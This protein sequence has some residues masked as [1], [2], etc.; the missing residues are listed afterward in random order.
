MSQVVAKPVGTISR[1]GNAV[2]I[3]SMNDFPP[4]VGGVITLQANTNYFIVGVGLTTANRFAWVGNVAMTGLWTIGPA[5]LTYTGT[6]NMFSTT[7]G[8]LDAFRC[9]FNCPNGNFFF[10]Q[11]VSPFPF[12]GLKMSGVLVENCQNL[13]EIDG[14]A[15]AIDDG[16]CFSCVNGFILRTV[17]NFT[18]SLRQFNLVDVSGT[19][20]DF[21]NSTWDVV[22]HRDVIIGTTTAATG[23]SGLPNSGNINVGQ[24]GAI[25]SCEFKTGVTPLAGISEDNNRWN[26]VDN[27]GVPDTAP[28]ALDNLTGNTLATVIVTQGAFVPVASNVAWTA[29]DFAQFSQGAINTSQINY[30]G[31]IQRRIAVDVSFTA[32]SA[33]GSPLSRWQLYKNGSPVS[34]AAINLELQT[35]IDNSAT[36]VWTGVADPTDQIELYVANLDGTQDIILLESTQRIIAFAA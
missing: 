30:T 5:Q 29:V 17:G 22:E 33:A 21:T 23:I 2:F 36:I 6:G 32:R 7:T 27:L 4:A 10:Q 1:I 31:E 28:R 11:S 15:T 8:S 18:H 25:N 9:V 35:G 3:R 24:Q 16:A 20:I 19:G 13:A 12:W 14:G 26:F 34:G